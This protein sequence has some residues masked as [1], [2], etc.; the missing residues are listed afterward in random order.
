MD[1][2]SWLTQTNIAFIKGSTIINSRKLTSGSSLKGSGTNA[3]LYYTYTVLVLILYHGTDCRTSNLQ[4][5]RVIS[6]VRGECV[7]CD[8][9][10]IIAALNQCKIFLPARRLLSQ[11]AT[12]KIPPFPL[13]PLW[14]AEYPAKCHHVHPHFHTIHPSQPWSTFEPL[15]FHLTR[16]HPFCQFI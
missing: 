3:G 9:F 12:N 13:L 15:A 14:F 7:V 8:R 6:Q 5:H 1:E 4:C 10:K 11:V 2:S 16:R